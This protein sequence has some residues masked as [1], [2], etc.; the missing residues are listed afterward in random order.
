MY[1]WGTV[2]ENILH[3]I[4]EQKNENIK[5]NLSWQTKKKVRTQQWA[6]SEN[7]K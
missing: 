4:C 6:V 1:L 5:E 2:S 3:M 7:L